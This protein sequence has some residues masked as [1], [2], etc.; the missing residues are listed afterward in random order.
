MK[1]KEI[2][3]TSTFAWSPT[4][5]LPLLATGTVAGALDESFSNESQLEIWAPNFLDKNEYDLG[6]IGQNG[7]KGVVKDS[8]RFNRL[9][10]GGIS[11]TRPQ[12]VIAAGLENGELALWDPSKILAGA[13]SESLILRNTTH[14]GPVRGL[15]FNPIQTTLLASG[16]VSGEVYIW[17]LK[18]PSKPYT[19]T[20]GS[21]SSKLDEITS[22][23]WNQ[24]VQYVLAGASSTGYTVVW[25]L[26]G[27]REVVALAY[28]GGAGTLAG[29]GAVG[30]GLAM[31][32]RRGMSD[33]AWHPDNATRLVTASEDDSSP[34]IM[35][36]DLR[37]AR[38]PEKILTGHEKGVLSLSWCKQ[39]ADLLLS[40][41]KDNRAL[42]WNPQ[43]SEIIGELPSADNWA[44][45]VDWCPRNPDLLATAFFDGTV[46]IHSI[47]STNDI[48]SQDST[49]A[50]PPQGAD[51]F[52]LPG[53]AR[54]TGATLSLKQPP[55]W[56]RRPAS[57]SFGFGGKLVTVSN[58]PSAQG[59]NQSSVVH[60]RKVVTEQDLVG[61]ATKLQ[62]AI[63]GGSEALKTFAEERSGEEAAATKA[64]WKALLSLFKADSRDELVTLLGFS[65]SEIAARV[66]EAVENL[67]ANAEKSKSPLEEATSENKHEPV[68]SF[69]EP[70]RQEEDSDEDRDEKTPS[71]VSASVTS[72]TT[73]SNRYPDSESTTTVPSLFGDDVPGTPQL[74]AG[75]D[76]FNSVAQGQVLVP[77][78]NYGVD[79]SVAATI[80]S[81]PSSVSSLSLKSNSFRI[82]P[83]EESDTDRLITKALVLGDFESAVS[84]CLSS[85]RFADAILLA[86]RGGP[87][88]LQRTQKAYFERRT[89]SIPYLR[90]FQSI[91]TN[92]LSDI[93][94]NADLQEWQE[95]FVVLCTFAS[96]EDFPGLAEELGRRLEFQFTVS[97]SSEKTDVKESARDYRQNATLTYLAAA[98]LERLVNIWID[99]LVEE[100]KKLVV[101]EAHPAGSRFSA[102]TRAL[103]SFVEKVTVF[104][105]ATKY[106][107]KD[108]EPSHGPDAEGR[109]YKLASLYDRYLEYAELLTTQGLVKEAVAF[110]K[111]TPADYKGSGGVDFSA[112]RARLLAATGSTPAAAPAA[113]APAAPTSRAPA[114]AYGGYSGYAATTQ[115]AAPVRPASVTQPAYQAYN[116]S[117]AGATAGSYAP[118]NAAVSQT[119]YMP[120]AS[121][122]NT[123]NM[124]YQ[125]SLT[126]PPHLRAQAQPQ[127][128]PVVPPPPRASTS[129]PGGSTAPPPPPKRQEN[130]GWNDAPPV[131]NT[132]RAP[133]TLN[134]NKPA[135]IT[136]PFPNHAASPGFSPTGSPYQSPAQL[137]S[138]PPPR[139]GSVQAQ[140][141]PPPPA[142]HRMAGPPPPGR[143]ASRTAPTPPPARMMSPQV[144][145]VA[146]QTPSSGPYAA[147]PSR[148]PVPGQTPPPGPYNRPT[149][150]QQLG[151]PHAP[152][153]GAP[154]TYGPA[155]SPQ[156]PQQS[157]PGPYAPPPQHA[158]PGPYAPP[159]GA[160]RTGPPQ[161]AG[162]QGAPQPGGGAAP[163]PSGPP[164]GPPRAGSRPAAAKPGPPPPKY[165]P[166]DRS[167]IPDYARPA[168][169]VISEHLNRM[170]QTTPPQQKRLVDDLE[171]RINPLFDALN[172]ETL[173]R[174]V[175][176]QLLVLTRA[177]EN[178]D[179]PAALAIHVDL[180]TRGSLTDDIGL[181]MSGVKQLIMRL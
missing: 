92:D 109:E 153:P 115:P 50:Q 100:E 27:K 122:Y 68:V 19:P 116:P 161:P 106:D 157:Q 176:D 136:S 121:A 171:R 139:P 36:W 130:G 111:L 135:A 162:P 70:E 34:I 60:I 133:A 143:P 164:S 163:P 168:F 81:R 84:L 3:R 39:D 13:G 25:D 138:F 167:H 93:V 29:H 179:R 61:R 148:G 1:L 38:A 23:A 18:D 48:P 74:D 178:H 20:P 58:L 83:S 42:C 159:P 175:V 2:H 72:D 66:A 12:G 11:D 150:Q 158:Q 103:Q 57:C 63:E 33:I 10:W 79:S 82:Y 128:T 107:D 126:Q 177:M 99:E 69:A 59:K 44:F 110:L 134:L 9:A 46:G 32:G 170:R 112:E 64:G 105:S 160:Q 120:A 119:P 97:A 77:H 30:T 16:G 40:C 35:V 141:P 22:V 102:H 87:E 62:T 85:D 45:Q 104:R 114:P 76:F 131:L 94:Q 17:D 149:G 43:T 96:Q 49:A 98:R 123:P 95:I 88:L 147:P 56:L 4:A 41:G 73:S 140:V 37:N 86:V 166:G 15:D 181:W 156:P 89:T 127:P 144:P 47:Q 117:G 54:S 129:T 5:S 101:D 51:I 137:A 8:A 152:T 7:P 124:P 67:K 78:T 28:G 169:N 151:Q 154:G 172:C 142:G 71:E 132:N 26:R 31:G 145:P 180:L 75:G 118:S 146:Q 65:K 14:T 165:P 90:L 6:G 108:L 80:G 53:F 52:D 125:Q 173:S 91:V 155:S 113:A 24:Q 174:Q 21:R 55:K